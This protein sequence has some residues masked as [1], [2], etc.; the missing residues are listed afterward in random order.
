MSVHPAMCRCLVLTALLAAAPATAPSQGPPTPPVSTR[1]APRSPA[2]QA[3]RDTVLAWVRAGTIPSMAIVVGQ[4][5]AVLWDEAIGWADREAGT[6]ATT[7]HAYPLGSVAKSIAATAMMTLVERSVVS[8]SEPIGPLLAPAVL[9]VHAGSARDVT[10]ERLLNASA[11]IPHGWLSW[12]DEADYPRSPIQWERVLSRVAHVMFAPGSTWEYSNF[13]LG[14][15]QPIIER[16]TGERYERY[17]ERAVFAPLGMDS[18]HA[19]VTPG[20]RAHVVAEYT[21]AGRR[22]DPTWSAPVGGLHAYASARDLYRFGRMHAG[23]LLPDQQP[24]LADSTRALMHGYAGG[25]PS[26]FALG[27]YRGSESLTTNGQVGGGNAHLGIHLPT[28]TVAVCLMNATSRGYGLAD[29]ICDRVKAALVPGSADAGGARYRAYMEQFENPYES[30]PALAGEWQGAILTDDGPR[31]I[32]LAFPD[33]GAPRVTITGDTSVAVG[34]AVFN[35]VQRFSGSFPATLRLEEGGDAPVAVSALLTLH[36][37]T[38]R[39][40]GYLLARFGTH[41]GG[42]AIPLH[43]AVRRTRARRAHGGNAS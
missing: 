6:A 42:F 23:R 33:S 27:W 20:M 13:S 17:V 4:G 30:T 3:I 8:L 32:T 19:G 34:N 1:I 15:V 12:N 29:Q 16:L 22:L 39:A 35:R 25:P 9:R 5:D 2:L 43:V 36:V 18:S 28:G 11:G 41:R 21:A 14:L 38:D 7:A 40:T 31:G 24:V 10:L 26:P 37:E